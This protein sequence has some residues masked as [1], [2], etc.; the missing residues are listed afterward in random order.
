MVVKSF[1]QQSLYHFKSKQV[2][3]KIQCVCNSNVSYSDPHCTGIQMVS[4][5]GWLMLGTEG[6]KIRLFEI[7]KNLKSGL[8]EGL[9]SNGST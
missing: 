4:V 2:K 7:R 3:L 8:F 5:S 9:I 6:S 1:D